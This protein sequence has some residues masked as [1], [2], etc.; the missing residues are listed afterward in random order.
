[1]NLTAATAARFC[2]ENK[3]IHTVLDRMGCGALPAPHPGRYGFGACTR[4]NA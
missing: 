1:L 3:M 4:N 2:Q